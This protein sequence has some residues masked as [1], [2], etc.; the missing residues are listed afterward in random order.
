LNQNESVLKMPSGWQQK[1]E[2]GDKEALEC[3]K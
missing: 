2:H 1:V 3:G